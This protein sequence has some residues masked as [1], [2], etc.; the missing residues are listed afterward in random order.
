MKKYKVE[1]LVGLFALLSLAALAW[2]TLQAGAGSMPAGETYVIES[3][4][5]ISSTGEFLKMA[6]SF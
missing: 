4:F 5:T 6:E 1:F 2:L 3:R